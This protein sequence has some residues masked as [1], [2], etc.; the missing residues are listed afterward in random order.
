M[1]KELV[2]TFNMSNT[3]NE[4]G[5]FK[6]G[7]FNFNSFIGIVLL[8][9]MSWVGTTMLKLTDKVTRLEAFSEMKVEQL[10]RIEVEMGRQ[11][12]QINSLQLDMARLKPQLV[13]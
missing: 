7:R 6:K 11:R 8:A 3:E 9:V 5:L 12:D 1:G 4:S 13:K 2:T 10:N